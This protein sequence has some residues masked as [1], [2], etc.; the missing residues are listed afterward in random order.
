MKKLGFVFFAL[1]VVATVMLLAAGH[2]AGAALV[3]FA[4]PAFV[5]SSK[6]LKEERAEKLEAYEQWLGQVGETLEKEKRDLNAEE[7]E[8]RKTFLAEI[9]AYGEKIAMAEKHE[10]AMQLKASAAGK[11]EISEQEKRNIQRYSFLK[12]IRETINGSELT[13]IERE[14]HDEAVK[15]ARENGLALSG[16]GIPSVMLFNKES[17]AVSIGTDSAGGYL[18]LKEPPA[19]ID[20]LLAK[21]VMKSLGADYWTGLK[22]NMPLVNATA[23]STAW[24]GETDENADGSPTFSQSTLSPKRL[25]AKMPISKQFLIQTAPGMDAKLQNMILAAIA[26]ELERAAIEGS[27]AS[28]EPTGII[29]TSGIGSVAIDTNGGAPT[30]AHILQ[31]EREVAVDNA[32]VGALAYL[33]NPKVRSKLKQTEKASGTAQFVWGPDNTLNGYKPGVTTNVPSDLTKGT[34]TALSAIIFGNFNDLVI[35]QFGGMDIVVDGYTLASQGQIR[36]VVNSWWD[37]LLRRAQS[38]AAIVDAVTT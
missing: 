35:G 34:G 12:A 23:V 5:R 17:R 3:A 9:D 20:A 14:M 13:G 38:F 31:L 25:G 30:W 19:L 4:M 24:E 15:E 33:T 18:Q 11:K 32:D 21:M 37:V 10:R 8:K 7:L 6:E 29:N 1:A 16:I 26:A 22:G 28:G 27:G 2:F 36:L